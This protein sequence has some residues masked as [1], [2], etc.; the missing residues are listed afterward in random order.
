MSTTHFPALLRLIGIFAFSN[1]GFAGSLTLD[2]TG[3]VPLSPTYSGHAGT[4]TFSHDISGLQYFNVT[5]QSGNAFTFP[6]QLT[7]FCIELAQ[8]I[9]LPSTG[10]VFSVVN[11]D[12]GA[13]GG[14]FSPLGANIANVGIGASRANNLAVLY[15]RRFGTNYTPTA[16]SDT[17]KLA[18]QLAVWELSHD[19]DFNLTS[20]TGHGFWITTPADS[21]I[22]EAQA[23]VNW[24]AANATTGPKMQ[25]VALHSATL[26]DFLVPIPEPTTYALFSGLVV[27]AV[28]MR[29]R[30]VCL[31][32]Q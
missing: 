27:L 11:P 22:T 24:V 32:I 14:P 21:A 23:L 4:G 10:N 19:D 18:F 31:Q 30:R 20:G 15:A 1:L 5:A 3:V 26:Q 9:N 16:L 29:R 12:Q 2:L 7:L 17:S 6:S 8:N 28:S 13:S 25:L